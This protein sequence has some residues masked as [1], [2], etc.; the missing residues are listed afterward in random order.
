MLRQ[1]FSF[2]R[3]AIACGLSC[4]T[5]ESVNQTLWQ[6]SF[7]WDRLL[8]ISGHSF[9]WRSCRDWLCTSLSL[10]TYS[11]CFVSKVLL[12]QHTAKQHDS[13]HVCQNRQERIWFAMDRST[14]LAVSL[15]SHWDDD[16][17]VFNTFSSQVHAREIWVWEEPW[18]RSRSWISKSFLRSSLSP[19]PTNKPKL[20]D[21]S[22]EVCHWKRYHDLLLFYSS[23]LFGIKRIISSLTTLDGKDLSKPEDS[24]DTNPIRPVPKPIRRKS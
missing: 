9:G 17:F 2:W 16:L 6:C 8:L 3:S 1:Y 5:R 21:C 11:G 13:H 7:I 15:C 24:P 20:P 12:H 19:I 14:G 18:E 10:V 22:H 4:I 23:L